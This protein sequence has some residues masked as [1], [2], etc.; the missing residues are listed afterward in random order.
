MKALW[1]N[2]R[3]AVGILD[4]RNYVVYD[5]TSGKKK[6]KNGVES[7]EYQFAYFGQLHQ[8][9]REVCCRVEDDEASDLISWLDS[10][11]STVDEIVELFAA[12]GKLEAIEGYSLVKK[13][14]KTSTPPPCSG[15]AL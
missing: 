12:G 11:H 5:H 10:F 7:V 6:R 13:P 2:E 14:K 4:S 3:Y 1:K 9:V 15:V 8:A